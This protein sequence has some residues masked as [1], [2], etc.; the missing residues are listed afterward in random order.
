MNSFKAFLLVIDRLRKKNTQKIIYLQK[1]ANCRTSTVCMTVCRYPI[2]EQPQALRKLYDKLSDLPIIH[3]FI[4]GCSGL[5]R[6][7]VKT[8][9]GGGGH[10]S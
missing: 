7:W 3:V 1:L 10:S 2:F 5:T 6:N 8:G 9:E 4:G